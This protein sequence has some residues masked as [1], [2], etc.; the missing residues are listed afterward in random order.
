M[1]DLYVF[2]KLKYIIN[3]RNNQPAVAANW[4]EG[5]ASVG[6]GEEKKGGDYSI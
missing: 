1:R 3:Q 2:T 4:R 6:D 5:G